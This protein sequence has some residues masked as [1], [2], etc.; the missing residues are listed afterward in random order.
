MFKKLLSVVF[1]AIMVMGMGTTAF[2]AETN[3]RDINNHIAA[4]VAEKYNITEDEVLN[5]NTNVKT[6]LQ[7]ANTVKD[8]SNE[9]GNTEKIVPVSEN[10]FLVLSAK[11]EPEGNIR[12]AY[13][14]T[15]TATMELKNILGGTVIELNSI[16]VFQTNGSTS[17]PVDAYGTYDA[18]VWNITNTGSSMGSAAYNAWVRNSFSGEFNIGIDPVSMTIKSFNYACKIYC[19]ANGQYSA[20]WS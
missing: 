17:T 20:N 16:G 18:W 4:Q 8:V 11:A 9:L 3:Q 14:R 6:A 10:L 7:T 13:E 15:I 2:A 5:L 12:A 19:N 1:A